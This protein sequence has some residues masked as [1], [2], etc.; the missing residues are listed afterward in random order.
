MGQRVEFVGGDAGP[1]F[2]LHQIERVQHQAP[3]LSDSLD[4]RRFFE[5]DIVLAEIGRC[6]ILVFAAGFA[7]TTFFIF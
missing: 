5:A 7:Q 6:Q 2:R 1:D 4:I 3:G